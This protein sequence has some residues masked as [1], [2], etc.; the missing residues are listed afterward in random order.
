MK[1]KDIR[2]ER[3]KKKATES[4]NLKRMMALYCERVGVTEEE[5]RATSGKMDIMFHKVILGVA[6]RRHTAASLEAVG[7]VMRKTHGTVI[8]YERLYN[9]L[10]DVYPEYKVGLEMAMETMYQM[11]GDADKNASLLERMMDSNKK[12]REK[13]VE[14]EEIIRRLEKTI[15]VTKD[16]LNT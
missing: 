13:L 6:L 16:V 2:T 8:R 12:L 1:N 5:I 14:K 15:K 11:K 7:D 4:L 3:V 10:K 9:E